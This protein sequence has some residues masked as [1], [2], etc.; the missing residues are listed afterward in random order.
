MIS[1]NEFAKIPYLNPDVIGE[2]VVNLMPLWDG[3]SWHQWLAVE[4]RLMPLRIME[5]EQV[6]Y[7]AKEAARESDLWVPFLDLMWQRASFPDIC[8]RITTICDDFH[9]LFTSVAKLRH[10]HKTREM[11]GGI[12]PMTFAATEIEYIATVARGIF[13]L[14]QEVIALLWDR[15]TLVDEDAEKRRKGRKLPETFSRMVLKDK[16]TLRTKEEIRAEFNVSP[17]LAAEYENHAVFFSRLRDVR[18][19]MVHGLGRQALV[20]STDKGFCVNPKESPFN[21]FDIW[22]DQHYLNTSTASLLPWLAHVIVHTIDACSTLVAAFA[23]EVQ[24]PPEIAPGYRI[25]VRGNNSDTLIDLL[26]YQRNELVWWEEENFIPPRQT[27]PDG[28]PVVP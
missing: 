3:A 4:G 24:F 15:V 23:T 2:R 12:V 25:F 10:F 20:Y 26:K 18:D 19:K 11:L 5:V 1:L 6:D 16:K 22:K 13:D 28:A 14:V 21:G 27:I 9:N 17:A 7:V 8:P